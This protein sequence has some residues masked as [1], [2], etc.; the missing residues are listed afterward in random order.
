MLGAGP[1]G[2]RRGRH[3]FELGSPGCGVG[4]RG[5]SC[6]RMA[7]ENAFAVAGAFSRGCR[8]KEFNRNVS[9]SF[10]LSLCQSSGKPGIWNEN[11]PGI[12]HRY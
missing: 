8:R 10:G 11:S 5:G 4:G 6:W 1:G 9:E 3:R 2:L 7:A 12:G